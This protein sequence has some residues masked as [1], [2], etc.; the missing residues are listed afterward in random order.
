M[1]QKIILLLLLVNSSHLTSLSQCSIKTATKGS[2]VYYFTSRSEYRLTGDIENGVA[3]YLF[4]TVAKLDDDK[5]EYRFEVVYARSINQV[6]CL[7]KT[8][9]FKTV[10]GIEKSFAAFN[11]KIEETESKIVTANK[12]EF[13]YSEDDIKFFST[14]KLY[15][16][17]FFDPRT[18]SHIPIPERF[19]I[20]MVNQ[21]ICIVNEVKKRLVSEDKKPRVLR[22][23]YLYSSEFNNV[24][25]NF[26]NNKLL[27]ENAVL[28]LNLTDGTGTLTYLEANTRN[29]VLVDFKLVYDK[30]FPDEMLLSSE[31]G[32]FQFDPIS[33]NDEEIALVRYD[34]SE[35]QN[36]RTALRL[37]N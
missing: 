23:K 14:E 17:S 18:N 29:P 28:S 21:M 19:Q 15:Q 37:R 36:V 30:E 13:N 22:T 12:F 20:D 25:H 3:S 6:E 27:G 2:A 1:Y 33:D 26:N 31:I 11:S 24:S 9:I 32:I 16:A 8:I 7:P 10:S 34:I 4:S 35:K 5:I